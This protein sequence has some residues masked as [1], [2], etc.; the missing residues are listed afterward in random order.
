MKSLTFPAFVLVLSLLCSCESFVEEFEPIEKETIC[1]PSNMTAT[2]IQGNVSSEI[3]AD[4]HYVP[5]THILDHISWSNRQIHKF[6]YDDFGQLVSLSQLKVDEQIMEEMW[7]SYDGNQIE[8]IDLVHR[9]LDP[10]YLD[11]LDSIHL[12]Y[13]VFEYER[14]QVRVESRYEFIPGTKQAEITWK[15]E[16]EYDNKGNILSSHA[17]DPRTSS[18]E[19]VHMTYDASKHPL[20]EIQY[21]FTGESFIN[22]VLS[23][24]SPDQEDFYNY[25]L[26][27]NEFGYAEVIHEKLGTS[28]TRVIRYSYI[29][30]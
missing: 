8:H 30:K 18:V 23:K 7:F 9:N 26:Q 2:L 4:F 28:D 29:S 14:N 15:V 5:D 27:L 20:S 3:V 24:S 17:F 25:E 22:N 11:P 21:Y 6:R 10:T 12:G 1:L 16:Y 13:M 19:S